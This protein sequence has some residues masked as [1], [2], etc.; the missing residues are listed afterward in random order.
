MQSATM[1]NRTLQ[2]DG[3]TGDVCVQKVTSA[4]KGVPGVETQSVKVGSAS[5]GADQAG[6]DA[7]CAAIGTAGFKAREG[8]REGAVTS[9]P[10]ASTR[11]TPK[12]YSQQKTDFQ[13]GAQANKPVAHDASKPCDDAANKAGAR[14]GE[15]NS[16]NPSVNAAP[17]AG[18]CTN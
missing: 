8:A 3:M 17:K 12:P 4:L 10:N 16:E 6:C 9:D 7:A 13:T 11:A 5:I 1:T 2:I 15:K 18:G 14:C